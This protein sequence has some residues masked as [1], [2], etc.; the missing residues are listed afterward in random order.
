MPIEVIIPRLG[1]S[2]EEA[3]FVNWLKKDGEEVKSGEPLFT[4]ESEKAAQDIEAIDS[5][6]LQIATDGPKPGDA[7]KAGQVIAYLLEEGET[8]ESMA[9]P[10]ATAQREQARESKPGTEPGVRDSDFV[11]ADEGEAQ[12]TV[13]RTISPRARR[14]AEQLGVDT[15]RLPGSGPMGRITEEDVRDAA[16]NG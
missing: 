15:T 1:W 12:K 9:M 13:K 14:L 2:I 7:V 3:Y 8:G 10:G 5:G 4:L 16:R 11:P 6:I